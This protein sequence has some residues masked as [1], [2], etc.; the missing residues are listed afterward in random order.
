MVKKL[1]VMLLLLA[2]F[3][4]PTV[5]VV[6]AL[7][8]GAF[9]DSGEPH[10]DAP[11]APETLPESFLVQQPTPTATPTA[12]ATATPTPTPTATATPTPTPTATA[13]P[14]PTPTATATATATPTPT[15]TA[16]A[17]A[18]P[19]PTP[20]PT[21]TATATATPTPTATATATATATP[22][23]TQVAFTATADAGVDQG[24]ATTNFG[25]LAS[26]DVRS[27]SGP[28]KK[29]SFVV[30][31]LSSIPAGSTISSATLDLCAIA[32]PATTRTYQVERVAVA[33]TESGVTWSSQPAVAATGSATTT[34]PS[35]AG[36]MSWTATTDVQDWV[37]GVASNFGWRV[38][39]SSEG[40]GP[41]LTTFRARE[42]V[43]VPPEQPKLTVTYT[44]P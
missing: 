17:T 9:S 32:V 11:T 41:A 38:R 39:D 4:A 43:G 8:P 1:W 16:T 26:M 5:P 33:W 28:T 31:D 30:F 20:T 19:T 36:C 29:R 12:T 24:N 25:A 7:F 13:T 34:T 27:G 10:A 15:A 42:D 6:L 14:T 2:L 22:T 44:P 37:N 40:T 35:V 18:T 3:A 21:A 23:P